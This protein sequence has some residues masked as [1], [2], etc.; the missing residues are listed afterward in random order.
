MPRKLEMPEDTRRTTA[1]GVIDMA[2]IQGLSS[3][4]NRPSSTMS[5][6]A[7]E[8]PEIRVPPMLRLIA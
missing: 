8:A 6:R 4:R 2:E 3:V 7:P 5:T 1:G